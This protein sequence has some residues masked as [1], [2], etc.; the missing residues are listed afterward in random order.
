LGLL[1]NIFDNTKLIGKSFEVFIQLLIILSI[2]TFSIETLPDLP[3]ALLEVLNVIEVGC[4]IIFSIE[5]I[6]RIAFSRKGFK[7]ILS[8]YGI[9]DLIAI[10]PFYISLGLDLRSIRVLRLLRLFRIFK[11]PKFNKAL[12]VLY[13]SFKSIKAELSIVIMFALVFIYL[14]SVGIYFFE[15]EA[16]PENFKSIFHSIWWAIAT[17]TTVGYGDVYPITLGGKIF[18]SIIILIG[19]GIVAIPTGLIASSINQK[20][21]N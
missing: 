5:Y 14:S 2:V 12:E 7:Y 15:N 20:I 3:L 6:G 17:L 9:I 13:K 11:L 16:Q 21:K 1:K 4:V 19:I 10:L 8:F 18:S